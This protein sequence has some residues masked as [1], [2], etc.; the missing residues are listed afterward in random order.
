MKM[1]MLG[2]LEKAVV[3]TVVVL[4]TARVRAMARV[5][6]MALALISPQSHRSNRKRWI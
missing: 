4:D 3:V 1:V 6:M 5:P 2:A